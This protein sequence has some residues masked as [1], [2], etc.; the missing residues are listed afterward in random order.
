MLVLSR[1]IGEEVVIMMPN[2]QQV[3]VIIS[4]IDLKTGIVKLA[5]RAPNNVDIFRREVLA[6][7]EKEARYGR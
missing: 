2:K 6:R 5:F 7:E 1:N 3:A 4:G